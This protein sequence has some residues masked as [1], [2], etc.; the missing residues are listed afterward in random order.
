V[1]FLEP[2]TSSDR[3]VG[4][5]WAGSKSKFRAA[6][7][8]MDLENEIRFKPDTFENVNLDP[9]R[10]YGS[11]IDA[12][13]QPSPSMEIGVSYAYTVA[14]FREGTQGGVNLEDKNVPLVPRQRAALTG[15]KS[16]MQ[17]TSLYG[18]VS[19]VGRQYFDNDQT[20]DFVEQMPAYVLVDARLAHQ[21][22]RLRLS[23]TV[24]NLTDRKYFSY[25]VRS[26]NPL[27]PTRFNAYPAAERG[28][29]LAVEYRFGD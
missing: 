1:A 15:R 23:A 25:G 5:E 14:K 4:V 9:T 16:W 10:R 2:Q 7:F 27:T 24:Q 21:I 13:W 17:G 3:E 22:G 26:I 6:L 20:N 11:E 29:F 8:H 18:E 28:V 19:Y 12:A